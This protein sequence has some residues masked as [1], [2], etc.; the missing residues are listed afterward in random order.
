VRRLR[1]PRRSRARLRLRG[2]R[3]W[4]LA[5]LAAGAVALHNSLG[6]LLAIMALLVFLDA[7]I[8]VPGELWSLADERFVRLVRKRAATDRL[9]RLRR[10]GPERLDVIDDR[11]GWAATAPRRALGVGPIAIDSITGTVED[12]KAAA[13]DRRFRPDWTCSGRWQRMWVAHAHGEPLPPVSVY[14]VGERH[15]LRDGH[16]RVSVARDHG[17]TAIEAD[18]VELVR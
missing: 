15:V 14:R 7:A 1:H 17:W 2:R 10:L 3:G 4:L 13:F 8:P 5:A 12:A 6:V 11:A 9:R 18:V 16:H